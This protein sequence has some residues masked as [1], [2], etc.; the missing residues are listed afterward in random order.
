MIKLGAH[1]SW[2]KSSYSGGNG[3]CVEIK[4]TIATAVDVKDSKQTD[5]PQL[6]F[7]PDAFA[8]FVAHVRT[9]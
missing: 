3:A 2:T 1:T 8:A 7:S 6:R 4:S 5:G 9:V